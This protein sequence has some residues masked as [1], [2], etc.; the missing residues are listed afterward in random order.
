M[1]TSPEKL[2]L[3]FFCE[4]CN[5]TCNKKG[6]W[7]RHQLTN[8]HQQIVNINSSEKLNIEKSYDCICGNNYKHLPSLSRHKKNC[9]KINGKCKKETNNSFILNLVE[10]SIK[11]ILDTND[12]I[13]LEKDCYPINNQLIDIIVDKTKKIEELK[14]SNKIIQKEDKIWCEENSTLLINNIIIVSRQHD[15]YINATQLC[16]AGNKCLNDWI[17][18][19]STIDL[20]KEIENESRL[21]KLIDTVKNKN[22]QEESWVYPDL[23]IH[24]A[25]WISPKIALHV[26]KWIRKIF[27]KS[28]IDIDINL[29]NEKENEIKLK[30]YKI[31]ILQDICIKK[32]KRKNY[33]EK[34]VIYML[35]TEDNEKKRIYIIGK[36]KELKNRLSSYNKTSEHEVVYYKE[37]KSEEIMNIA[38]LMVLNKLKEYREKANRDRFVLPVEKDIILFKNVID[39]SI[40]FFE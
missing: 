3:K 27:T 14:K 39:E 31:K 21:T 24:V 8:K 37:C 18:L 10:K 9:T 4:D 34:Y 17:K 7:N 33:P 40:N 38:E 26:T 15:N 19:D 20:I 23:A 16:I 1:L 13:N 5:F 12:K 2:V 25:H 6:D 29:L 35:T 32:Q 11:T 36:A 22:N 30:D 28:K